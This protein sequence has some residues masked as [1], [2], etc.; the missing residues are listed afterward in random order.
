MSVLAPSA[1]PTDRIKVLWLIKGLG[2][3]G[4]EQLLLLAA[5]TVDRNRFEVRVAYAR[6]DKTH[7]VQEF[8][9]AGITPVRLG[10]PLARVVAQVRDLRRLMSEVEVV[11][12]HSPVLASLARVVAR[13]LPARQ[14]PIL[15]ST[16]HNEWT[17][18]RALTR[19]VNALTAPLDAQRW[20][21]SDQVKSTIWAG[22]RSAYEVLIH[23]IELTTAG[24]DPSVRARVRAGLGITDDE[25]LSLTVANLRTNKD[26]PNLLRAASAATRVEPRLRFAAVGQGPLAE[27]MGALHAELGLGE[28]FQFLGYRR[29]VADLMAAADLFTLASAHEGLPVAVMEAFAAGLPVVATS[30]GGLPQQVVDGVHGRLVKPG[31]ADA[32]ASALVDVARSNELR[33]RMGAAARA[34]A[35]EYDIRRAVSLQEQ[36]YTRLVAAKGC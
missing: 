23:G 16:E 31:D 15:V 21:V 5:K 13:T 24:P 36:A 19:V 27:E 22:Q 10:A 18:H 26:Y 29:D 6:P 35:P 12:A 3:G 2:P 4:A 28:R 30:V 34:R 8:E 7:L 33:S 1:A 14:R 11:H 9:S 20:A 17:S 32:L 25:V